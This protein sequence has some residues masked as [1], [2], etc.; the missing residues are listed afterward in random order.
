MRSKCPSCL[1]LQ[2][3]RQQLK[4]D[5]LAL[6]RAQL[7]LLRS[8]EELQVQ[9]DKLSWDRAQYDASQLKRAMQAEIAAKIKA[10]IKANIS[11]NEKS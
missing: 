11:R 4:T 5:R 6:K 7:A 9:A 2:E 8:K 10:K 1:K 3:G